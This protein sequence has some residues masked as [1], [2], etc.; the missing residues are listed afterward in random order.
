MSWGVLNVVTIQRQEEISHRE[1]TRLQCDH[2]DRDGSD[3]AA[4]QAHLEPSKAGRGR[5][6]PQGLWRERGLQTP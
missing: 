1:M 3:V 2:R 4:G 6:E 5:K